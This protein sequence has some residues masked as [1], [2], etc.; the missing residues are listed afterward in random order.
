M[1]SREGIPVSNPVEVRSFKFRVGYLLVLLEGVLDVLELLIIVAWPCRRGRAGVQQRYWPF[2]QQSNLGCRRY[3]WLVGIPRREL[4][5]KDRLTRIDRATIA[6]GRRPRNV[7]RRARR[8]G[9]WR[10]GGRD[11]GRNCCGLT[12]IAD[13]QRTQGEG[14]RRYSLCTTGSSRSYPNAWEGLCADDA[15][16]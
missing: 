4:R 11:R 7:R 14:V 9:G 12:Y 13:R 16:G 3:R 10:S 5:H 2:R 8:L 1:K 6:G 15:G